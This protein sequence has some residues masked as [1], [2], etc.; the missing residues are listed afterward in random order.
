VLAQLEDLRASRARIVEIGD[1]E[2]RRLE[3]NLHDGAQQR[4]LAVSYDLRVTRAGVEHDDD[5]ELVSLLAQATSEVDAALGELRE[6][7]QG[8]YPAI[9]TEAGLGP[10][11]E[12][13]SD[14]APLPLEL[15]EIPP[16]R[17]APAVEAAAYFTVEEAMHDAVARGAS[18]AAVAVARDGDKLVV[19]IRDDGA[20]PPSSLQ[21][22]ADRVGA[23]GGLVK[24]DSTTLRAELPCA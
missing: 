16:E 11:L 17:Y 8:I 12:T 20:E 1:A 19:S 13:L 7:A 15:G 10:A 14:A 9:L 4:L 21:R 18:F 23:L 3:R 5:P 22:V 2:R 24:A 6:L